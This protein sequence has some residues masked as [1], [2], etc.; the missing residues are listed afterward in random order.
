MIVQNRIFNS[1]SFKWHPIDLMWMIQEDD[2]RF[3]NA[4]LDFPFSLTFWSVKKQSIMKNLLKSAS[5]LIKFTEFIPKFGC[6]TIAKK[7]AKER[8]SISISISFQFL[9]Y[10]WAIRTSI[11]HFF[12]FQVAKQLYKLSSLMRVWKSSETS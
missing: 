9:R 10:S 3:K 2:W 8:S 5:F 4:F 11:W 7:H 12:F 1:S 6:T